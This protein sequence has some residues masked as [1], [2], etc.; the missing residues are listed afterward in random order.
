MQWKVRRT[1]AF[2][3]HELAVILGEDLTQKDL[4]PVFELFFHDLDEVRIGVL[5]HLSL[6]LRMLPPS[7]RKL[8]LPR[9]QEFL[10]LDNV[11]NWRFRRELALQLSP[12]SELF[13]PEDC[14]QHLCPITLDLLADQ[15]VQIRRTC[16]GVVSLLNFV[17]Y[18]CMCRN[19]SSL[20]SLCLHSFIISS[21]ICTV[22]EPCYLVL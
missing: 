2:S 18:T 19:R 5:K 21:F 11:N 8:F 20:Y 13:S 6:F 4:L 17:E 7:Q 9:L 14:W 22:A 15:V 12:I 1:L 3:I 16:F 10:K